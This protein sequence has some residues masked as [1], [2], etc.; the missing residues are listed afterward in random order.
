ML[1]R[2]K[3]PAQE[4]AAPDAAEDPRDRHVRGIGEES[5]GTGESHRSEDLG[6]SFFEVPCGVGDLAERPD[7]SAAADQRELARAHRAQRA[8][9]RAVPVEEAVTEH[10]SFRHSTRHDLIDMLDRRKR[11]PGRPRLVWI[12]GVE[13]LRKHR[14]NAAAWT[15]RFGA[16][17]FCAQRS[18]EIRQH[19]K[20]DR[21][22][23]QL[24]R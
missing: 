24:T 7:A 20:A 12:E 17:A 16:S 6:I 19:Q 15:S 14:R 1:Y 5:Q 11:L 8:I 13:F 4:Q 22:V 10:D 3:Q 21:M 9:R 18:D 23:S 2:W